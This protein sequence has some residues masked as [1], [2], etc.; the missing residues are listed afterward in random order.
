M[1]RVA[2]RPEPPRRLGF[3]EKR[4]NGEGEGPL[5]ALPWL[6]LELAPESAFQQ[7][8]PNLSH[9][10]ILFSIGSIADTYH[11]Q[12][13]LSVVTT[14][15]EPGVDLSHYRP[16]LHRE[17][18][19]ASRRYSACRRTPRARS[20]RSS[21]MSPQN[22]SEYTGERLRTQGQVGRVVRRR[23]KWLTDGDPGRGEG[24]SRAVHLAPDSSLGRQRPH[25]GHF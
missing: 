10:M 7:A 20:W 3:A 9:S 5:A 17:G 24:V 11:T 22:I 23:I 14:M 1:D 15:I 6:D 12:S 18:A 8:Q 4:D 25:P 21:S 2:R 13:D 16:Y 19:R